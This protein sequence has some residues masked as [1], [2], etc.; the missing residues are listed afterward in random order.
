[1]KI[2]SDT[3]T[4]WIFF[5]GNIKSE[6]EPQE[7]KLGNS[8]CSI[9]RAEI[10]NVVKESLSIKVENPAAS[11]VKSITTDNGKAISTALQD[12]G[13]KDIPRHLRN[14]V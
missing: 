5:L 10:E 13:R 2:N 12:E 7:K 14:S 9:T 1:M 3:R 8:D 4:K 11:Q 6:K